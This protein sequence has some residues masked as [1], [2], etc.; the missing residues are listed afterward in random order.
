MRIVSKFRDYYDSIQCNIFNK[1]VIYQRKPEEVYIEKN[2]IKK[3]GLETDYFEMFGSNIS[4]KKIVVIFCGVV[5]YC[6]KCKIYKMCS[7]NLVEFCYSI[8]DLNEFITKNQKDKKFLEKFYNKDYYDKS[9]HSYINVSIF[10]DVFEKSGKINA[11]ELCLKYKSPII[12]LRPKNYCV[13]SKDDKQTNA[14][15]NYRLKDICFYKKK[16]S[17]T[18]FQEISIFIDNFILNPEKEMP[19]ISDELKAQSKGFDK[20][21]FRRLPGEKK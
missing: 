9:L 19:K 8:D 16:D 15:I 20:W 12:V 14:E 1:S 17:F 4:F 10:E 6:I 13:Y 2:E 11:K 21:S 5:F 18:A 7:D 3:F